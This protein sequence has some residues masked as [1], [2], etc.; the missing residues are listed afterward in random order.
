M[1]EAA[2]KVVVVCYHNGC[3]A[4]ELAFDQ[5][6]LQY[7]NICLYKVNT[8]NSHDI[9]D[10]YAD[11]G[12]KPYFKFYINN[13]LID[14]VKYQTNWS[15]NEPVLIQCLRRHNGPM[16]KLKVEELVNLE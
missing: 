1:K 8:L 16:K 15:E 2:N 14:E 4:A 5:L 12:S 10:K 13:A 7:Q 3:P 9:R 11:G 6:K